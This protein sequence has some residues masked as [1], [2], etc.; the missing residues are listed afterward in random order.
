M[1]FK[2]DLGIIAVFL[3]WNSRH[4]SLVYTHTLLLNLSFHFMPVALAYL[5]EV[6]E[7][8][9]GGAAAVAAALAAH[10]PPPGL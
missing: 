2:H 6:V 4:T 3:S 5:T 8:A 10:L 7:V 1:Q 9:A